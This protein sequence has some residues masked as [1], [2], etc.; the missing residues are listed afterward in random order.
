[1]LKERNMLL[2]RFLWIYSIAK[3]ISKIVAKLLEQK[4]TSTKNYGLWS[5]Y[6]LFCKLTY[7]LVC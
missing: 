5:G 3:M 4:K 2:N 1:M 7:N 6:I